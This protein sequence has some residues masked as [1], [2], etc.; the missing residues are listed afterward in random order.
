MSL[1]V[2]DSDILDLYQTGH[3]MV[4]GRLR[5]HPIAA[6]ALVHGGTLVTR[7]VRDFQDIRALVI[8]DWSSDR[9]G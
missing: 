7:N 5:S 9:D 4:C 8:A 2:L 3:P 6:I 1:F